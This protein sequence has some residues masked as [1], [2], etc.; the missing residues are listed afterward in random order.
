[1]MTH[2]PMPAVVLKNNN[3]N[4]RPGGDRGGMKRQELL[5]LALGIRL[6]CK[7][8]LLWKPVKLLAS[9]CHPQIS[10]SPPRRAGPPALRDSGSPLPSSEKLHQCS[11]EKIHNF[12]VSG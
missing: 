5:A 10:S 1:M 8:T 3:N 4:N 9:S 6:G 7:G 12:K 2:R 11:Y